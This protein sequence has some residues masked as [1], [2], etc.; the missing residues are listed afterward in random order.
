MPSSEGSIGQIIIDTDSYHSG[1]FADEYNSKVRSV[2]QEIANSLEEPYPYDTPMILAAEQALFDKVRDSNNRIV[3]VI[4]YIYDDRKN[5]SWIF[6]WW[7]GISSSPSTGIGPRP[8]V[9]DWMRCEDVGQSDE[10]ISIN[11]DD[12][13]KIIESSPAASLPE[14]TSSYALPTSGVTGRTVDGE[15]SGSTVIAD[16]EGYVPSSKKF[17]VNGDGKVTI[18]EWLAGVLGCV[19]PPWVPDRYITMLVGLEEGS[20]VDFEMLIS[21]LN[22]QIFTQSIQFN[23]RVRYMTPMEQQI[24]H[25]T[26]TTYR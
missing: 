12:E 11:K 23:E 2:M 5:G 1:Y 8:V 18:C 15:I 3:Q 25:R 9:E 26:L 21:Q 22:Q 6:V 17:D 4:T 24:A 14:T 16:S 10:E 13:D 19:P 7:C 20:F